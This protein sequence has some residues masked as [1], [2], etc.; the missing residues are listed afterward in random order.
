MP[1]LNAWDIKIEPLSE[2][3]R[4]YSLVPVGIGT[5]GVESLK[6]TWPDWLKPTVST[7]RTWLHLSSRVQRP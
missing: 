1:F 5:P 2:R 6:V 4:L 3:S 7:L